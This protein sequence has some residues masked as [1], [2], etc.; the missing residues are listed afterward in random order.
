MGQ[1][2]VEVAKS[3]GQVC[4]GVFKSMDQ[5]CIGV[6]KSVGQV[7]IGVFKSMGQV[8]R[9]KVNCDYLFILSC[10]LCLSKNIKKNMNILSAA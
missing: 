10:A 6:V 8:C 3:V 4:I 7:C 9:N 2:C 5:V 1:V